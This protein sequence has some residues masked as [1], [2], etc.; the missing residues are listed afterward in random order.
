MARKSKTKTGDAEKRVMPDLS[1]LIEKGSTVECPQH[2]DHFLAIQLEDDRA[3]AFAVCTCPVRNNMWRGQKVW[4]KSLQDI[5]NEPAV[6]E[7]DNES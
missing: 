6:K 3:F 7:I 4:V 5:A 1:E 2:P